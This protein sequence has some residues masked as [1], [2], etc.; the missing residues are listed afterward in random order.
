MKWVKKAA[1]TALTIASVMASAQSKVLPQDKNNKAFQIAVE[2]STKRE[3][4]V[5]LFDS[6][7]TKGYGFEID[8]VYDPDFKKI[9]KY[10]RDKLKEAFPNM[11]E[12]SIDSSIYATPLKTNEAATPTFLFELGDHKAQ[13]IFVSRYAFEK[14][15]SYAD[16]KAV[17]KHEGQHCEDLYHGII[18]GNEIITKKSSSYLNIKTLVALFEIR[19]Q[20][21]TMDHINEH[22]PE[23]IYAYKRSHKQYNLLSYQL[24]I[25]ALDTTNINGHVA[26]KQLNEIVK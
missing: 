10:Q 5:D 9:R 24:A 25:T 11:T 22:S 14:L 15:P 7:L 21:A 13:K 17:I 23:A 26:N 18:I 19:A 1:I 8:A 16:F 20:M 2:D 12:T 4:F 6:I 3:M